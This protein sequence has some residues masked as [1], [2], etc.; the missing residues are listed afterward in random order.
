MSWTVVVDRTV[1]PFDPRPPLL[2]GQFRSEEAAD[3]KA[4]KVRRALARAD[5][6]RDVYTEPL[7]LGALPLREVVEYAA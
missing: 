6:D 1:D 2:L 5:L 4:E 3:A 7:E